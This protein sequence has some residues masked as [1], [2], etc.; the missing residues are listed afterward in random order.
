MPTVGPFDDPTSR[1]PLNAADHGCFPAPTNVRDDSAT[2]NR[3]LRVGIVVP[4]V[5]AQVSWS[6]RS[7]RGSDHHRIQRERDHPL[8]VNVR[9]GDQNREGN[10]ATIGEN[11]AFHP[12][13]RP[14]R[15]VR[16]RID[17]PLG[18]LAMALSND[19]KS[20]LM[21]RRLS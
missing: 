1:D 9:R 18:A 2:T 14:V 17:P 4:L 11:V 6:S 16:A 5:Q 19:A 3:G 8:V 10:T 12:E 15:R 20:H 7:A 21:P 13:F